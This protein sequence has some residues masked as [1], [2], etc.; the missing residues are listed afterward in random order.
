[1]DDFETNDLI[2]VC[3]SLCSRALAK[4]QHDA[5]TRGASNGLHELEARAP[6]HPHPITIGD[7]FA[8]PIA[9]HTK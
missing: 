8:E 2:P 4:V 9:F 7:F 6:S 1:M 3:L 5:A